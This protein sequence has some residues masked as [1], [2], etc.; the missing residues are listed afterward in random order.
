M[1]REN[2]LLQLV[3]GVVFAGVVL[4]PFYVVLAS[5]AGLWPY[6]PCTTEIRNKIPGVSGL[7][8]ET[9]RT[10]CA[11]IAKWGWVSVFISVSGDAKKTLL[12]KYDPV[13]DELPTISVAD[14]THVTITV[15]RVA[16]LF[17]QMHNWGDVHIEYR[18]GHVGP[19]SHP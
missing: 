7:D 13:V 1:K 5:I 18:I 12:F 10:D 16:E 9:T 14:P 6:D 2:A 8:F 3:P 19:Y 11:A 4:I 15:P 17:F